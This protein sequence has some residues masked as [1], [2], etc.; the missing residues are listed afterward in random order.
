MSSTN[1]HSLNYAANTPTQKKK[2]QGSLK[3]KKKKLFERKSS[4][5]VKIYFQMY[6]WTLYGFGNKDI[7]KN[8]FNPFR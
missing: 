6:K 7:K 4:L 1:I 8:L 3:K 5:K 2:L